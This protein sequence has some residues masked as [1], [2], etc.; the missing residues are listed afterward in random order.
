MIKISDF[1]MLLIIFSLL[2]VLAFVAGYEVAERNN[3]KSKGGHYS[4]DYG[5]CF[6]KEVIK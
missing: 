4:L 5:E 1:I 6:K 3:C 2:I